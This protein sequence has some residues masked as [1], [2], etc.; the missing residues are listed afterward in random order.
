MGWWYPRGT[1]RGLDL[2]CTPVVPRK[3]GILILVG[4]QPSEHARC[5]GFFFSQTTTLLPAFSVLLH[6]LGGWEMRWET[7]QHPRRVL[8]FR[9]GWAGVMVSRK[10]LCL[11][12]SETL[13][14]G[15]RVAEL[16]LALVLVLSSA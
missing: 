16:Q 5:V 13:H 11:L 4:S 14:P 8:C 2:F 7:R 6:A 15:F 3:R 9:V 12:F 10:P 1:A